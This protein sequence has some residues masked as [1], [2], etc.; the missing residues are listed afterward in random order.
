MFRVTNHCTRTLF[1]PTRCKLGVQTI[2]RSSQRT[3]PLFASAH[4]L[5][6]GRGKRRLRV[7]GQSGSGLGKVGRAPACVLPRRDP[8]PTIRNTAGRSAHKADDPAIERSTHLSSE[9]TGGRALKGSAPF[10]YCHFWTRIC[11]FLPVRPAP[12][13]PP[14][15]PSARSMRVERKTAA[16]DQHMLV[17]LRRR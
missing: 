2:L 1:K 5:S 6:T 14:R 10:L 12:T 15:S 17:R 11:G 7:A 9:Q 16:S 8:C 4:G 13:L 3:K